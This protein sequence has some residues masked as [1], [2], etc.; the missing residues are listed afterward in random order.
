[1]TVREINSTAATLFCKA[2]GENFTFQLFGDK[3]KSLKAV[4]LNGTY[5]ENEYYLQGHN[6]MG[7]GVFLTV[8]ETNCRGRKKSDVTKVR[9]MFCDFDG[10][11]A[12][13]LAEAAAATLQPSIVVESSPGKRHLYWLVSDMEVAE[14]EGWMRKL[15]VRV[16]SDPSACDLSRVLRIPGYWHLKG[17]PVQVKLLECNEWLIYE[18]QQI[19]DAFALPQ[20]KGSRQETERKIEAGDFGAALPLN[21][22]SPGRIDDEILRHIDPDCG[23][24]LWFKVAC[25]LWHQFSGGEDGLSLFDSWSSAAEKYPGEDDTAKQYHACATP[26]AGERITLRSLISLPEV[27][28]A[29][30]RH[31][32]EQSKAMGECESDVEIYVR[33]LSVEDMLDR[34]IFISTGSRV[35]DTTNPTC[36]VPLVEFKNRYLNSY[37][38]V[39]RGGQ[40][41]RL[42]NADVWLSH[43][44]RKTVHDALWSPGEPRFMRGA[45]GLEVINKFTPRPLPAFTHKQEAADRFLNHIAFL[46]KD[47]ADDFLDWFAH[48]EQ[49]PGELPST[50]WLHVAKHTGLGRN[51][52]SGLAAHMWPSNVAVNFNLEAFLGGG[53][54]DSLS[55]KLLICVDEIRAAGGSKSYKRAEE[56]KSVITESHRTI[57]IKYGRPVVEKNCGRWL[58]FSNHISAIPIDD[59]DRRVNVVESF[60]LPM[61]GEYYDDLYLLLKDK[62]SINTIRNLL[63]TRDLSKFKAGDHAKR[64]AAKEAVI[65]SNKSEH[66]ILLQEFM[67]TYKHPLIT[68]GIIKKIVFAHDDEPVSNRFLSRIV[69][70]CG[71]RAV[72]KLSYMGKQDKCYAPTGLEIASLNKGMLPSGAEYEALLGAA[73][74]SFGEQE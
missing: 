22:W 34:F 38:M 5:E 67:A 24:D 28:D 31:F 35:L 44:A 23:Y 1:M 8:N 46:F 55:E 40:L 51:W 15:I 29:R 71:L 42:H 48:I 45:G 12:V 69:E 2:L 53:F 30:R 62:D 39:D 64:S 61:C 58:M 65:A 18:K 25:A 72:G 70:N 6:E 16:G 54:G 19:I 11:D 50:A 32:T 74:F 27:Q 41:K 57:N 3:D 47:R 60:D 33:R 37:E 13:A 14:F 20:G 73:S 17:D 10:D 26:P 43:A 52:L 68:A 9:A 49:K 56:L 4:V 66:Q 7:Y 21:G 59:N 36:I 63:A